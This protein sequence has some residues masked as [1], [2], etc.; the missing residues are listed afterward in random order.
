MSLKSLSNHWIL[1]VSIVE[2]FYVKKYVGIRA[3]L[4]AAEAVMLHFEVKAQ[5]LDAYN[6]LMKDTL[7]EINIY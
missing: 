1:L 2:R 4:N 3:R 5:L 6:D 7:D